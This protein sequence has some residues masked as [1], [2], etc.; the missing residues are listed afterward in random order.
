MRLP[1]YEKAVVAEA[2]IVKYLLN[3]S[4]PTGK[5]KAVFFTRFGFSMAQWTVLAQALLDH[6]AAHDV[7]S[8]LDTP[9]G[10]HYVIEGDLESPD[11]RDPLI[12]SVWAID[13]D[14]DIPRFIT[15]YPLRKKGDER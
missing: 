9:E 1:N 14:S 15:A 12:R 5:D 3:E 11:G 6:A 13:A 10:I 8:T 2:K 4:H 7:A